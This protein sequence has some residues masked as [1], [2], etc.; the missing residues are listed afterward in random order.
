[1]GFRGA[2]R[3]TEAWPAGE[4]ILSRE[5]RLRSMGGGVCQF[6]ASILVLARLLV[7]PASRGSRDLFSVGQTIA[8]SII[9]ALAIL[10]PA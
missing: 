1:M 7:R 5:A 8:F 9:I 3:F 4:V 2:S 6:W 10:S